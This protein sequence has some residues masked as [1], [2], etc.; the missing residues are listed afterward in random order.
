VLIFIRLAIWTKILVV[1][2]IRLAIWTKMKK[3]YFDSVKCYFVFVVYRMPTLEL[4]DVR[5][6]KKD[7]GE[8]PI[9]IVKG[10]DR[11]KDFNK[12]LVINPDKNKGGTVVNLSDDLLFEMLPQTNPKNR[13]IFYIAGASGSGKSYQAK[14]LI[15]NYRKLHPH[16]DVFLVSK[17]ESDET[18]DGMKN[19]PER[20]SLNE[21]TE[22]P[23][24]INDM[25]PCLYIFDDWDTA[26][27]AQMEAVLKFI[28]DISIMGRHA[29]VSS[30]VISHYLTNY[31][32][33][34][35]ILNEAHHIL[36]FP[37]NTSNHQ[38]KY[39]LSNYAGMDPHQ[40]KYLRKLGRWA[41]VYTQYP[42]FV[43]SRDKAYILHTDD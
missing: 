1:I 7:S 25:E 41:S 16:R 39:L 42:Q 18:L 17:L 12:F 31:K 28:D 26:E 3:T 13:D 32:K 30:I 27:K 24:D 40:V 9:A 4:K 21:F 37:Q 8:F 36:V 2:F 35:L 19:P 22:N 43:V 20:I 29:T 6:I 33:T 38:L 11:N 23:P 14:I 10:D 34:R 5:D 15:S